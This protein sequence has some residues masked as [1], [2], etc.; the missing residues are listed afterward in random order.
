MGHRSYECPKNEGTNQRNSIVTLT[1]EEGTQVLE[2]E[3]TPKRGESLVINKVLLKSEKVVIEPPKRKT[4][5]RSRCQVQGKCCQLVIDS[6]NTNN[7]VSNEVVD[8]LKLK[9]MK[10]P[11]PYKVSWL[12][13]LL[14]MIFSTK[15]P[16]LRSMASIIQ[17]ASSVG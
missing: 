10:H 5:F 8:K 13:G 12:H 9:T 16:I 11:T 4:L 15:L 17:E 2:A 14:S 1:K 7:L 6:G 3:N